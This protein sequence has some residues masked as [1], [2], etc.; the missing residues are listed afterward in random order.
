MINK[1]HINHLVEFI[2]K[3]Y[4]IIFVVAPQKSRTRLLLF[5]SILIFLSSSVFYAEILNPVI[6][7]EDLSTANGYIHAINQQRKYVD[8]ISIYDDDGSYRVFRYEINKE[9]YE[10]IK[11]LKNNNIKIYY[12]NEFGSYF[13]KH[14]YIKQIEHNGRI[15]VNY[16]SKIALNRKV[17]AKCITIF[18]VSMFFLIMYYIYVETISII[19]VKGN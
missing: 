14:D 9:N 2:K 8:T 18:I 16:N 4:F 13:S 10:K 11:S 12:A 7:L 15:V 1:L 6:P 19:N 5:F 3:I 17:T